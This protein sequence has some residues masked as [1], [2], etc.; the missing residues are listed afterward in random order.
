[1]DQKGE[2]T[3]ELTRALRSDPLRNA[4]Q[5]LAQLSL[6]RRRHQSRRMTS[7]PVEALRVGSLDAA[8]TDAVHGRPCPDVLK[9]SSK[10]RARNGSFYIEQS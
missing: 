1:M 2:L 9:A 3:R 4:L 10:T 8:V 5:A 6:V 7:A